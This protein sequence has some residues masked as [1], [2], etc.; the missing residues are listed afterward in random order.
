MLLETFRGGDLW[1]RRWIEAGKDG[2]VI[3]VPVG[4]DLR[5]GFGVRVTAVRDHQ[6]MSQDASVFVPWDNKELGISFATF[7]DKLTPGGRETW[8]VTV[9][10]PKGTSGG[11]SRP[12]RA[13]PSSWPICTTAASTSSRRTIRPACR[14][15]T[16]TGREPSAWDSGLGEAPMM[17]TFD[18]GWNQVPGYPTFRPDELASLGGYGIGGP[19]NRRMRGVVGG[20]V[21]GVLGGVVAEAQAPMPAM[22]RQA[23]MD[24]ATR[25]SKRRKARSEAQSGRSRQRARRAPSSARISPRRPSG[26]LTC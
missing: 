2:G 24:K 18:H 10:T 8:R 19:G 25:P 7:R 26:S 23:S 16:P 1:E 22:A 9:K 20:V 5:G 15:S 17:F 11:G 6:F 21:G 3:E 14:G 12:R 13:R 4:E